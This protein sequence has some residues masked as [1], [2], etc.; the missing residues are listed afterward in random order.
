MVLVYDGIT[1]E[2]GDPLTT[3][4]PS[5]CDTSSTKTCTRV[6]LPTGRLSKVYHDLERK[7]FTNFSENILRVVILRL[8]SLHLKVRT[9]KT[10]VH[11]MTI[12]RTESA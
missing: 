9:N 8:P 6:V 12:E 2:E 1:Q 7:T 3:P 4:I 11:I 10:N 5:L